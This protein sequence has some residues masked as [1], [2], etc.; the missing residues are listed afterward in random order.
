MDANPL[1]FAG[2]T[3]IGDLNCNLYDIHSIVIGVP[4]ICSEKGISLMKY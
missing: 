2:L 3:G 1:T 4:A